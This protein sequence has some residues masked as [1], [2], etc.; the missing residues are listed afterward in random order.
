M[1]TLDP[2]VEVSVII[3][4]YNTS[5]LIIDCL[6]SIVKE[7]RGI[8]YEVIIV[9]NASE[10]DIESKIRSGVPDLPNV[11]FC[12]SSENNGFGVGNNIGMES[13]KGRKLLFL[14]PDTLL[15]NNA[16]KILSDFLD[17]NPR[18]AASGAN[19]FTR[20]GSPNFSFKR[21]LPGVMW[22]VNELLHNII[23]KRIFAPDLTFNY[24]ASPI[25]VGYITGA[26]LMVKKEIIEE[27]GGFSPD[28]FL[29]F[30]ETDLCARIKESGGKIFNVPS[31]K[32]IHLESQSMAGDNS[33][34]NYFKIDNL[35]KS[36]LTYYKR[37]LNPLSRG[38]GLWVYRA[39]LLSRII[40]TRGKK[41]EEYIY[42]Y[43]KFKELNR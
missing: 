24:G 23:D 27:I 26:D 1:E 32:I 15:I 41:R 43:R 20:E 30:E 22:E 8:S 34:I 38:L 16:I 19:L 10:P 40:A 14:N 9:D 13:A 31:A 33:P 25:E 7:T 12:L 28:F 36:H 4:N 35:E 3:V 5:S 11:K 39:F 37:N 18:V 2:E 21:R 17:N 6:K 42:R 29:Y